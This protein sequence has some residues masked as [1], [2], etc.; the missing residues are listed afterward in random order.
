MNQSFYHAVRIYLRWLPE[1]AE[2]IGAPAEARSTVVH[3]QIGSDRGAAW[4]VVEQ[5]SYG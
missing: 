2:G 3:W 5:R 1:F 4:G